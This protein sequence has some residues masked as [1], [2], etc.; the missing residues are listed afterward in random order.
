MGLPWIRLECEWFLNPKFLNLIADK[1]HRAVVTYMA[2][3]AWSGGQGQAGF[4]PAGA[5]P[6]LHGTPREARDLVDVG[7][8]IPDTGGWQINGWEDYQL[9]DEE[10]QK[11]SDKARRAAQAR[12]HKDKP[13]G[14]KTA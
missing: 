6:M 7:L 11:R 9:A 1:K 13:T 12:W 4:I 2:G 3:I 8:W 10:H 14:E 5:L